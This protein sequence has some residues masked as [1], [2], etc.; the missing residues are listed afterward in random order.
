MT[1]AKLATLPPTPV[2]SELIRR[3]ERLATTDGVHPTAL[4]GLFFLRAGAP[5]AS[6]PALYE[7]A[8][9]F[10]LQGSKESMLDGEVF[11]YDPSSFLVVT[12]TLPAVGRIVRA[13]PQQPYLCLRL[14]IDRAEIAE[15]LLQ[16]PD[17]QAVPAQSRVT[18]GL[19]LAPMDDS[20][21]DAMLRLVRLLDTPQDLPVLAPL[22]RREIFYRVL[23]SGG[24]GHRLR[25]QVRPD[26]HAERI[27]AVLRLLRQR[28]AEPIRVA[29]LAAAAHMSV[30][31]LHQHF[32]AV[33]A[34]SPLQYQKQL[35]LH[36]ARHLMM[37]NGVGASVAAH[38]VG[39]ESASQFSRE[40]RR[41]FGAPP[42]GSQVGGTSQ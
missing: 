34:M 37:S 29:D 36:E 4:S 39:Y 23:T 8:L 28:Y 27:A 38:R 11:R 7:P 41:L 35:R 5:S 10:V 9:C 3:V 26:S 19:S 24:I 40:Y 2:P 42:T 30:S 22:I 13:N 18:R 12:V 20:L 31:A 6:L 15:L 14:S 32:R 1:Q 25:E 16:M 33:T 17:D 21:H